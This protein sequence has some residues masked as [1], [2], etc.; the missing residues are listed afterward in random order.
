[1]L[2]TFLI[3]DEMSKLRHPERLSMDARLFIFYSGPDDGGLPG[4]AAIETHT[5]HTGRGMLPIP[6]SPENELRPIAVLAFYEQPKYQL[7]ARQFERLHRQP[8]SALDFNAELHAIT[9]ATSSSP[10]A[11]QNTGKVLAIDRAPVRKRENGC[12]FS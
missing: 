2:S 11:Q 5:V 8:L 9:S 10:S 3:D 4:F 12:A 6:L 1:M 7:P